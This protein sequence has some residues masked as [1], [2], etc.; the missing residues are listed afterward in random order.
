MF[1][2]AAAAR[3]RST[4]ICTRSFTTLHSLLKLP[5]SSPRSVVKRAYLSAVKQCHPDTRGDDDYRAFVA[6]QSAWERYRV[7]SPDAA[8]DAAS[9][10]DARA[11]SGLRKPR[12]EAQEMVLLVV[13]Y[14]D[15]VWTPACQH[16]L[17]SAITRAVA[18]AHQGSPPVDI[19]RIEHRGGGARNRDRLDVHMSA[20]SARHREALV[21]M[22]HPRANAPFLR[23]LH[24]G[25][26][27]LD[28][29]A[30]AQLRIDDCLPYSWTREPVC[31]TPSQSMDD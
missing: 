16:T 18:A 2:A 27:D 22:M 19:R 23:L 30:N 15:C 3:Q 14:D 8:A 24:N 17:T 20:T 21:A 12:S 1:A 7:E 13:S 9:R 29:L 4:R 25:L 10:T 6:L 5:S 31:A 11:N 28:R 26:V